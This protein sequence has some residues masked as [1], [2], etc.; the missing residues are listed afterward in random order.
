M[1]QSVSQRVGRYEVV[2]RLAVGGMAEILLGRLTGPSGFERSV[3]IKKIL[4]Q[5]ALDAPFVNMFLDEARIAAGIV[6]PNVVQHY[7]L[8]RDGDD[9]FLVMEYL[10][11]E[12]LSSLARR[13]R[14][15]GRALDMDLC[16]YIVAEACAGLH[17][18]HELR[19]PDGLPQNLVHR[20]ISPQNVFLTYSG[21]VKILDFG[22]AKAADRITKTEAGELKG[23]FG[24]MSPEQARGESLDRRS[25]IFA[26]GIVLYEITTQL[27]LF[28]RST[29]AAT[30]KAVLEHRIA[31]PSAL[32]DNYPT[33]LETICMRALALDR[34]DR[35]QTAMD[36]RR[37]LL[38]AARD[39]GA[40]AMLEE[41]LARTM[42]SLFDDRIVL[43]QTM[44][45]R[46]R[47]GGTVGEIPTPEVDESVEFPA[48][49]SL[50]SAVGFPAS[51]PATPMM[52]QPP[53]RRSGRRVI[54]GGAI[55]VAVGL[56]A[57]VAGWSMWPG[58]EEHASAA[59]PTRTAAVV[60]DQVMEE[61]TEPPPPPAP[62]PIEQHPSAQ[63]T[64]SV[65]SS[66]EKARV[67]V[68]GDDRGETPVD[69]ELTRGDEPVT[70]TVR[71]EGYGEVHE[72][73]VPTVDQHLRV[74]L[75]PERPVK[76]TRRPNKT[77]TPGADPARNQRDFRRFD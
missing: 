16:A 38:E 29:Q 27:Y 25:D 52:P 13:A 45:Q 33:R 55:A 14:S 42:R 73:I 63:V 68:G 7:E 66:P 1:A 23:K 40:D 17:A 11:G 22:I 54:I 60:A 77:T 43:K 6:H 75:E 35:Y 76:G 39:L 56:L 24:Y 44:L 28:K 47:S 53:L 21:G 15:R 12:T 30:L 31:P 71:R 61:P 5:L 65:A 58:A 32:V 48:A 49:E 67:L 69:I 62:V 46:V 41:A 37:D 18:A 51:P 4:P 20:D 50:S 19:S 26:L 74:H 3:V 59:S 72:E 2:A 36:M 8:G 10:E 57:G 9:L 34:E 70:I 64:V